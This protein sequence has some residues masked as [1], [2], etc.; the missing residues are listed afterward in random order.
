MANKTI[1][2][3]YG[4]VWVLY[5]AVA[6][7]TWQLKYTRHIDNNYQIFRYSYHHAIA[8]KDLYAAYP[9]EYG[10]FYYYGPVFPVIMAPLALLPSGAGFLLWEAGNAIAL[11]LAV[12]LLPFSTKQKVQ[13]LL[14]CAIEYANSVFY[15][16]FNPAIAAIIILSFLLVERG[17]EQWA[18]MLIMLGTLIKLYPVVG[19]VFFLFSKNKPKFMIWLAVWC[20]F[21]L[22]LPLVLSSPSFVYNSYHQWMAAVSQKSASNTEFTASQDICLMGMVRRISGHRDIPNLPFIL[23]GLVIYAVPL[24]RFNQFKSFTFRAQVLASSLIM[25]I[26][27]STGAEHPTYIIAVA[28]VFIW[29]L[30]QERPYTALNITLMIFVLTLT[31]LGLTD[32]VPEFIR[33]PYIAK[34]SLKALPVVIIWLIISRELIFKDFVAANLK[35]D[36]QSENYMPGLVSAN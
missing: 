16:Q 27:F 3:A 36:A 23:A 20:M 18:A 2:T 21:F 10:D 14:L 31:G 29:M 7:F 22:L 1:L 15:M 5:I 33:Q 11:L 32:A 17:K 6:V 28:G 34:Y 9:K 30:I 25:V 4:W 35:I 26:I 8:D 19:L 12:H 13:L 24:L